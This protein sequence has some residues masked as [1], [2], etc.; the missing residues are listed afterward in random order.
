HPGSGAECLGAEQ[1]A[2]D[3]AQNH[4]RGRALVAIEDE[5]EQQ[6]ERTPGEAAQDDTDPGYALHRARRGAHEARLKRSV[7]QAAP[8]SSRSARL[9]GSPPPT[10]VSEPSAPMTRWHGTMIG[11]G[12][13]PFASPT[14][15]AT[16]PTR[17]ASS[18]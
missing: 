2:R 12:L 3:A 4:P 18:A 5:C 13:A 8:S 17:R 9:P 7:T 11:R 14:A 16:L 6:I 15:R 1:A 10:P